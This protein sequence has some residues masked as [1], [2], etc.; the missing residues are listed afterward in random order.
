MSR[1]YS[2]VPPR[3]LIATGLLLVV[4][5]PL[6][7]NFY[8]LSGFLRG[9]LPGIGLGLEIAGL[10]KMKQKKGK[11]DLSSERTDELIK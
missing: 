1:K 4:L 6:I 5:P 8:P 10:I 9:F 11:I 3:I 2:Q 7:N